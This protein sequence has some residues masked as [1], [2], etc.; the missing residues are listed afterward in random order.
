MFNPLPTEFFFNPYEIRY[1]FIG[2]K[3]YQNVPIDHKGLN[4]FFV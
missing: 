3:R 2:F 4:K 1:I